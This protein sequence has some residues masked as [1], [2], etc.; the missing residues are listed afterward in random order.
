MRAAGRRKSSKGV[1]QESDEKEAQNLAREER[2]KDEKSQ[3]QKT[4]PKEIR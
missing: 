3:N 2:I 1:K 4:K